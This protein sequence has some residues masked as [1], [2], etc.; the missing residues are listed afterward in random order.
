M[1]RRKFLGLDYI[2]GTRD[3]LAV[4]EAA[5][6]IQGNHPA[7]KAARK[8]AAEVLS[9]IKGRRIK[10]V[11]ATGV[12]LAAVGIPAIRYGLGVLAEQ[13]QRKSPYELLGNYLNAEK[14]PTEL[15]LRIAEDMMQKGDY[16]F[17]PQ[18]GKILEKGIKEPASLGEYSKHFQGV[19]LFAV[20][21]DIDSPT[22]SAQFSREFNKD[23]RPVDLVRKSDG[24]IVGLQEFLPRAGA[25]NF[26]K[27]H[28]SKTAMANGA[29]PIAYDL[30]LAKELSHFLLYK[31]LQE[32]VT[33]DLRGVFDFDSSAED[34]LFNV[35]CV[36]P[37]VLAK[38]QMEKATGAGVPASFIKSS[39]Y[40][41]W[42]GYWYVVADTLKAL[43][44]GMLNDEDR[45]LLEFPI[46][47]GRK[48]QEMGVLNKASGGY[49]WKEGVGPVSSQWRSIISQYHPDTL[50]K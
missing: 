2:R 45:R 34:G 5:E 31:S 25:D 47:S 24:F 32:E 43:D 27:I 13:E 19:G 36:A 28:L 3:E 40:M 9:A 30:L 50:Y 23:K 26:V 4:I 12:T 20:D 18:A 17:V 6:K 29:S 41:D 44:A 42:G 48:A 37:G 8:E 14:V 33:R 21:F 49:V 1:E 39:L 15:I 46:K 38:D 35:S 10:A 16:Q 7:A 11:G 22:L